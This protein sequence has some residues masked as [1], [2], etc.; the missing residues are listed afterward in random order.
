MYLCFNYGTILL[1][2]LSIKKGANIVDN[3]AHK[4]SEKK[5]RLYAEKTKKKGK[6]FV[7]WRLNREEAEYLMRF[8]TVEPY[9]Y[10]VAK[11]F[12]PGYNVKTAPHVVKKVYY[13]KKSPAFV[14]MD[15]KEVK[16]CENAGLRPIPYKYKVSL[17]TFK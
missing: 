4:L 13:A 9:M 17:N 15:A 11:T 2:K 12:R 14:V 1:E 6:G 8:T 16:A 3:Q 10:K 7:V 5:H